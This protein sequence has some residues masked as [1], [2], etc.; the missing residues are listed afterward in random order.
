VA[1]Q[2]PYGSVK[3][4]LDR[5]RHRKP[6][7]LVGLSESTTAILREAMEAVVSGPMGTGRMAAVKGI[8]VAGKTGT[9]QN[10]HGQD[11]A[12]FMGFA[13]VENPE[14]AFAIVVENAGHGGSVAAPVASEL[15][16]FYFYG[17]DTLKVVSP[18][19]EDTVATE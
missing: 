14:I 13:P 3:T 7:A 16:R 8:R 19:V 18:S 17:P 15:I 4:P 10:P 6:R 2:L 11:H 1:A 5:L 12:L 9:A